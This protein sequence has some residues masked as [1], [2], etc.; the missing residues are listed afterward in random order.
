MGWAVA[1]LTQRPHHHS[2]FVGVVVV[3]VVVVCEDLITYP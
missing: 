3:V 1:F 2:A